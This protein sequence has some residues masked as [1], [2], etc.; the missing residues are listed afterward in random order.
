M[1]HMTSLLL[2]LSC[3]WMFFRTKIHCPIGIIS[4]S[5]VLSYPTSNLKP[6]K[7]VFTFLIFCYILLSQSIQ[8]FST[9]PVNETAIDYHIALAQDVLQNCLNHAELQTEIYCQLIK[10]TSKY[11]GQP[12]PEGSTVSLPLYCI[13]ML[14]KVSKSSQGVIQTYRLTI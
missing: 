1:S 13:V 14:Y 6:T 3:F 4:H 11:R 10:Q 7:F 5:T 8:L 9:T 12:Q 2:F